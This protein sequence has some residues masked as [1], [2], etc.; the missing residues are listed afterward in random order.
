MELGAADYIVKPFSP[1]ELLAR[2]R[3][4][5][6]RHTPSEPY[7]AGELV[8]DHLE[9]RVTLAGNSLPLTATEYDLLSQLSL[10]AGRVLTHEVL[11]R[12]VWGSRRASDARVVRA[13]VKKLRQKLG[14]DASSP[15]YIFTEAQVGYRMAKPD[16]C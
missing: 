6:R 11:L 9:R 15:S 3:A 16:D 14:D 1:T 4:V 5:L 7:Q 8:I 10:N 12:R 2:I 13:F